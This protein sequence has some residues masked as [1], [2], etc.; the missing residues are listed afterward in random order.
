M[1]DLVSYGAPY[2]PSKLICMDEK[3]TDPTHENRAMISI[4]HLVGRRDRKRINC[5][6]NHVIVRADDKI[7]SLRAIMSYYEFKCI[8]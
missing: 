6:V 3:Y 8:Y 2:G 5:Y 1:M 7:H 4:S